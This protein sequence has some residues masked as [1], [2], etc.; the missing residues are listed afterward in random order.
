MYKNIILHLECNRIIG[1]VG[2]LRVALSGSNLEGVNLVLFGS[3]PCPILENNRNSTRIE[4]TVPSQVRNYI[5]WGTVNSLSPFLCFPGLSYVRG[6]GNSNSS[7]LN[8]PGTIALAHIFEATSAPNL[9]LYVQTSF[10]HNLRVMQN[11]C[12]G[13]VTSS[14]LCYLANLY[15]GLC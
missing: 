13:I 4:C 1:F 8:M 15:P 14:A 12:L 9:L 6:R 5:F 3:Q 2:G 7:R 11:T 10:E